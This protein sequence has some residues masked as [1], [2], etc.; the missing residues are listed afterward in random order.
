MVTIAYRVRNLTKETP[1]WSAFGLWFSFEPV[2][3]RPS[4]SDG[5]QNLP[6]TRIGSSCDGPTFIFVARR[7]QASFTW[8]VPQSDQDLMDGVG[9]FGTDTRKADDTFET[10][11]LMTMQDDD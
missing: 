9:A 8:L 1:F 11:L 6:W 2:L 5:S 10:L 3:T 7:R 4:T